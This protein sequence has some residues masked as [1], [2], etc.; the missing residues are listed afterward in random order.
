MELNSSGL[1][2]F[3]EHLARLVTTKVIFVM[4]NID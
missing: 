3:E 4:N 1:K 2:F